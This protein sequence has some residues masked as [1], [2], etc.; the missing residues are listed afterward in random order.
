MNK[1][2]TISLLTLSIVGA[3]LAGCGGGGGD[4]VPTP[5]P[6]PVAAPTPAPVAGGPASP[7][8]APVPAPAPAAGGSPSPSPVPAPSPAPNPAPAP[9][10]ATPPPVGTGLPAS[11]GAQG[12]V[13][14]GA[15]LLAYSDPASAGL[16]T[17]VGTSI[18]GTNWTVVD[19][20]SLP[21]GLGRVRFVNNQYI[22]TGKRGV[23][24]S[25]TDAST[26]TKQTIP[27]IETTY[28]V[29]FG[30]GRYI[31]AGTAQTGVNKGL[32]TS[33]DGISWTSITAAN[34]PEDVWK[35]VTYGAGKFVAV[36]EKGQVATSTDGS[37]W[38]V[39]KPAGFLIQMQQVAYSESAR[40]F[41]AVG[42]FGTIYTSADGLT[43]STLISSSLPNILQLECVAARCVMTT[44]INGNGAANDFT[45]TI[46]TSN[47]QDLYIFKT[48]TRAIAFGI[49]N[50]GTEWIATGEKGLVMTS[51]NGQTWAVIS[52]K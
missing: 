13:L 42:N 48:T 23:L 44:S 41:L 10:P 16:P 15:K 7:A 17:R 46:E 3:I 26:W 39:Y 31:L 20:P 40:K 37:T 33:T 25:S 34:L 45:Y 36:G 6:A 4:S 43:W 30:G 47:A 18:D 38:S 11:F 35:G 32:F 24:L 9:T 22:A 51:Q 50:L 21:T 28:D 12:M 29:A 1:S 14:A 49:N 5:V 2:K 27:S 19:T 52:P 8:P